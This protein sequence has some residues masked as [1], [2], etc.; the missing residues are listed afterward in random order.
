M[1]KEVRP[2]ERVH[3][4]CISLPRTVRTVTVTDPQGDYNVY[5]NGVLPPEVQRSA[6]E[7]EL[8]HIGCGHFYN[9]KPVSENELEAEKNFFEKS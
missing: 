1:R 5:V 8:R 4:R 6:L 9:E 2:V 3:V 7:H